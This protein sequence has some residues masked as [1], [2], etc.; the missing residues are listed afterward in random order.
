M[1]Y[2]PLVSRHMSA[3]TWVTYLWLVG[4]CLLWHELPTFGQSAHVCYDISYL[5]LV[6]RYMSVGH[7]LPTLGQ[8]VHV[9]R[10]WVTYLWS[11]GTCLL[12][13]ELPTFGQ[14]VHVCYGLCWHVPQGLSTETPLLCFI[15]TRELGWPFD[16]GITDDQP[17]HITLK[18]HTHHCD[19][20]L[21]QYTKV[22]YTHFLFSF[23]S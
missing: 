5:P 3:L 6:S 17:I 19:N 23:L 21:Y 14:S 2:L 4:T 15:W 7:E 18:I 20:K 13:H 8:S 10:T 16:C 1:S 11:V 22:K 12:W 9:C